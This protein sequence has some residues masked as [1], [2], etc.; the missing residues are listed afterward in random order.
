M[1]AIPMLDEEFKEQ[2]AKTVRDLAAK[3]IVSFVKDASQNGTPT[4]ARRCARQRRSTY[5]LQAGAR[6][7][8]F[9]QASSQV[10]DRNSDAEH[11]SPLP[12]RASSALICSL[13][14]RLLCR[15]RQPF[16]LGK[17]AAAVADSLRKPPC[18]ERVRSPGV[19]RQGRG[20]RSFLV[21]GP[22]FRRLFCS[23]GLPGA[24]W[25]DAINLN[26]IQNG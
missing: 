10:L 13:W 1:R 2:C 24:A 26:F 19:Q 3:A 8:I 12:H 11:V 6:K 20:P 23:F 7:S 9:R 15:H 17:V 25:L 21:L 5:S 22:G 4:S 14:Y 16:L 18:L